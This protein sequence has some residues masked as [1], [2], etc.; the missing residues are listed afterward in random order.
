MITSWWQGALAA[1]GI[2]SSNATA[3]DFSQYEELTAL[4]EQLEAEKIYAPGEL[5]Q[6]FEQVSRQ[7]K[8]LESIARP[9]EKSK[10]WRDYRPIFMT[11]ARVSDGLVFWDKYRAEFARAEKATGVPASMILAILG[12]ETKYG[13]N[14]GSYPVIEALATLGFDYPPRAPFFRKELKEFLILTKQ[15]GMDPL[16]IQGSYA[17]A[18]GF[19][20]FMPSSWRNLAVDF[21]GDSRI[22]LIN[23]PVDAIGSIANYFKGNGWR[24]GEPVVVRSRLSGQLYDTATSTEL[25][26]VSTLQA[27]ATQGLSPRDPLV[28]IAPATPASGIRLQGMNGGEFWIGFN[29]FYVITRYNRSILYAMAAVQLSQALE[30]AQ[31]ERDQAAAAAASSGVS[32][33]P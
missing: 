6:L 18:M 11:S 22:D 7:P 19:P 16:A 28:S 24:G 26:T 9:A 3:G 5:A 31:Q 12:I 10:E 14:K 27:L 20:Q 13:G 4:I 33:L 15:N 21:D 32:L 30:A 1:L 2:L 23:N 8:V 25:K 29:N 17:G